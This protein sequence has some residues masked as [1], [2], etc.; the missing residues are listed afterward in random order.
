MFKMSKYFLTIALLLGGLFLYSP[1]LAE[2]DGVPTP[3]LYDTS[4]DTSETAVAPT[5]VTAE[6][7][8]PV[9]VPDA[10]GLFWRGVRERVSL[11]V[12]W[13]P[14]KK[15]E[16]LM[17]FAEER[18]K[19][20]EVMAEK[21]GDNLELQ[22]RAT[23]MLEK[24]DEFMKRVVER[25]DQILQKDDERLQKI[26]ERAEKQVLH[27]EEVIGKIEARLD[28][29]RIEKLQELR[30][31]G[32]ESSRRLFNAIGNDN[33]SAET[34]AHLEEIGQNIDAHL[35]D[36]KSFLIEKK[37]LLQRVQSG[38]ETAKEELIQL[39]DERV[40]NAKQLRQEKKELLQEKVE[41]KREVINE[42][43]DVK[44]ELR[45]AVKSGDVEAKEKLQQINQVQL[46]N[47][48]KLLDRVEERREFR[49]DLQ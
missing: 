40:E 16:K 48:E 24:S 22:N 6:N 34:K 7:T 38:D 44:N 41:V 36:V 17:T 21:A 39:R 31:E 47:K 2:E 45:E 46:E 19:L 15:T 20:A 35:Q 8:E 3:T 37:D 28:P 18:V 32:L 10:W 49:N 42:I 1:V 43:K 9:K 13:N 4:A 33:I 30:Q 25:R 14:V 12:T 5:S 29:Q 23:K 11:A 26:M 27:R